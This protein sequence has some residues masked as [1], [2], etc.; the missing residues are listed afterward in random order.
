MKK[1]LISALTLFGLSIHSASAEQPAEVLLQEMHQASEQLSYELSY[2]LIKK[3]S[4]E[5]LLYRH[6]SL[7]QQQLA[8]L[9]YLSGPVR[10]VIRRGDEVS[11]VEPGI[12]PFTVESSDMVAPTIPLLHSDIDYLSMNY[13]FVSVGRAREAGSATQVVRIVPKDGMRYSYVLWI[14]ETTRLPL[15]ADLLDRDGE[16]LEQYRTISFVVNEQ[17]SEIM[18]GLRNV[19]L[20]DVLSLPKGNVNRAGWNVGWV[21][22]GFE[23]TDVNRYRMA[24]TDRVVETQMYTD[25]LF[26]FSI[27]I[28]ERDENSLPGQVVRQGRRTLHTFVKG[29][30]EISVVGDIPPSTA[31][32]IAQSVSFDPLKAPEQ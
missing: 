29:S 25:G 8:H 10:E 17:I 11:Y 32:R 2:I 12:E 18:S 1:I 4:I 31:Q 13:D 24:S 19:T 30:A 21:P 27:Y 28:A 16:V 3:N 15:R 20:P 23:P 9:L 26:N 14:D 5:P 7:E 22:N 6:A